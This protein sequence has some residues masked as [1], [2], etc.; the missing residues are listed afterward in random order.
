MKTAIGHIHTM[1]QKYLVSFE[2]VDFFDREHQQRTEQFLK[3][4]EEAERR[5]GNFFAQF[6]QIVKE[7]KQHEL[8]AR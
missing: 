3:D 4:C 7:R 5:G 1:P 6:G 2:H 8:Q